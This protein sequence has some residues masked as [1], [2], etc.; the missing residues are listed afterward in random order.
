MPRVIGPVNQAVAI[1][2]NIGA[3]TPHV[4]AYKLWWRETANPTWVVIAQGTTGDQTPDFCQHAFGLGAQLFYW[5]GVAGKPNSAY[6]GIITIGQDGKVLM[7]GLVSVPGTTN[8]KGV[9]VK[10]DWINFV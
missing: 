9:D 4:V 7:N 3:M 2:V 8:G 10:Q 6:D 1:D 5:F